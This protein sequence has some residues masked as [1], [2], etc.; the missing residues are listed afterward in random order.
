MDGEQLLKLYAASRRDFSWADLQGAVLNRANLSGANLYRAKLSGA[1]LEGADLSQA[2][3]RGASLSD[4]CLAGANLI[5]VNFIKADLSEAQLGQADLIKAD[6]TG[7]KLIKADLREANLSQANF[8]RA[9]L[10]GAVL[11][12]AHIETADFTEANLTGATMPD[13]SSYE[14]WHILHSSNVEL[15]TEEFVKNT[16]TTD[17]ISQ[18]KIAVVR[19]ARVRKTFAN[20]ELLQNLPLPSLAILLMG[21]LFFGLLLTLREALWPFWLLCWVG[22]IGWSVHE[23]FTWLVPVSGALV[24]FVA[25][26]LSAPSIGSFFLVLLMG[27]VILSLFF[28]LWVSGFS[29]RASLKDSPWVGGL[30]AGFFVFS[31]WFF[32]GGPETWSL[33]F[34]FLL[35]ITGAALGS[36]SWLQMDIEGYSKEQ[37]LLIFGSV[38]GMGLFLG[39]EAGQFL[40]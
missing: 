6:L 28:G 19:K 7:A 36:V 35:A 29:F 37:N 17:E 30:V 21:Y 38:T 18:K 16:E 2:S 14:E 26:I 5:G 40:K 34:N 23:S 12:G 32:W 9:D 20:R 13:G 3:L 39:F 25:I 4:A 10:S 24:V 8:Y 27:M 1:K 15:N 22:S 33:A 11:L 31:V